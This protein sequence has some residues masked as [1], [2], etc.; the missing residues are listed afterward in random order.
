M[1]RR[2]P[3]Q[4]LTHGLV[5]ALGKAVVTGVYC[6]PTP[7]P[8]EADLCRQFGASRTVV[9]EAVK[10]LTA[11]GLLSAR[12]RRGTVVEPE[13]NWNLLDPDVL[14]WL[15]SRKFSPDLLAEFTQVR[16][17]I[18]PMAAALAAQRADPAAISMIADAISRM[19][20]AERGE[21]DPLDS[22]I[23]FHVAVLRASGN[24]FYVHLRD[25]IDTALR[26]SIRVTNEFKGVPLGNVADHKR[27]LDAIQAGEPEAA[28]EAMHAL[29]VEVRELID[30]VRTHAH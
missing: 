26:F 28:R 4:N 6:E 9:R 7:F 22:D 1:T 12:P 3:T 21:D 19:R 18:E 20:A 2:K 11:K 13:S 8:T 15:L 16:L 14:R 30:A 5:D 17:A 24:R 29:L 23:A 25:M 10:M 27:V